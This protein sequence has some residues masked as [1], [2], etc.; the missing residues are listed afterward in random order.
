MFAVLIF[1]RRF[2]SIPIPI[3]RPRSLRAVVP[4]LADKLSPAFQVIETFRGLVWMVL[5]VT[6]KRPPR[7]S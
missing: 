7:D 5:A 6:I 2:G 3:L 1:R 4:D